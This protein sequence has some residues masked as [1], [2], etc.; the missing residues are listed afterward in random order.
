[1]SSNWRRRVSSISCDMWLLFVLVGSIRQFLRVMGR[2]AATGND[3]LGVVSVDKWQILLQITKYECCHG[4]VTKLES[5]RFK[6]PMN[7]LY[8]R[9]MSVPI[10]N[11]TKA[12]S[13]F[14]EK[15]LAS[16]IIV[17][18]WHGLAGMCW[19]HISWC[20]NYYSLCEKGMI[21]NSESVWPF[22]FIRTIMQ[23]FLPDDGIFAW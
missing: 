16:A 14:I 21:Y 1:M 9:R 4:A 13:R 5:R 11:E 10:T 20:L 6:F 7:E 23:K 15:I 12:L 19:P 2:V 22:I 18:D 3:W 17:T 8:F